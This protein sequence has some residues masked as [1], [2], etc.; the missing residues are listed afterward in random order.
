MQKVKRFCSQHY[1]RNLKFGLYILSLLLNSK[2][3]NEAAEIFHDISI[4]LLSQYVTNEN[5]HF[6]DRLLQKINA[7]D[8]SVAN[9]SEVSEIG[10]VSD[11]AKAGYYTEEQFISLACFSPF[12]KWAQSIADAT[13]VSCISNETEQK[14]P[15]YSEVFFQQIINRYILIFPLWGS[16]LLPNE[17]VSMNESS[18][19]KGDISKTEGTIENKFRI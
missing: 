1:K 6:I 18:F 15:Y 11:E 12:K 4:A 14:N 9:F 5:R 7:F 8:T 19:N 3:L 17:T 2:T 10:A 13:R 16:F